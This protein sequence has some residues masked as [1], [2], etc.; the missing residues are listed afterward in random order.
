M[1]LPTYRSLIQILI[2]IPLLWSCKQN[3]QWAGQEPAKKENTETVPIQLQY[4]GTFNLGEGI[5]ISNQF[6]GARL[7]GV[8]RTNDS[9]ITVLITPENSPINMSPWYAFKLWSEKQQDLYIRLSYPE[10][11]KHRYHPKKSSDGLNWRSC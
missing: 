3:A 1:K 2:L 4:K 7:N 10:E 9:L 6:E 8:A 11:A 5:H